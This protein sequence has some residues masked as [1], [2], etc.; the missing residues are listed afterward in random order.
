VEVAIL[1]EEGGA[2]GVFADE[3]ELLDG[4]EVEVVDEVGEVAAEGVAGVG[5]LGLVGGDV[6]VL[7]VGLVAVGE[8]PGGE[9]GHGFGVGAACEEV[10]VVL[11]GL[12]LVLRG[13]GDGGE[14]EAGGVSGDVLPGEL[15]VAAGD[16][17]VVVGGDVGAV[18]PDV[19]GVGEGEGAVA[20]GGEVGALRAQ[21]GGDGED[22]FALGLLAAA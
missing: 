2:A 15:A 22:A 17:G 5:F 11:A 8:V 4:G 20:F 1:V 3:V 7:V 9:G 12:C 14:V 13:G 18:Q 21:V 19:G 10:G 16:D 6:V